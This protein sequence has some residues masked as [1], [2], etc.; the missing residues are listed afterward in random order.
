MFS[1][2]EQIKINSSYNRKTKKF[3]K[4]QDRNDHGFIFRI[5]GSAKYVFEN[6]TIVVNEG[7]IIFLPK[8]STYSYASLGGDVGS[9]TSINF[10]ADIPNGK[11]TVYC[12]DDYPYKNFILSD[13][14]KTW[15]LATTT[16]KFKCISV[17]YSFISTVSKIENIK[18]NNK[19]KIHLIEP[20]LDYLKQNIYDV[21]FKID[22]LH[23]FCGISS[24]YFRKIFKKIYNMTPQEYVL[25]NRLS[26]AKHI[27]ESKDY[28]SIYEVAKAVGFS[29]PLYFSKAYKKF[30]GFSPKRTN[31]LE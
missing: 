1:N 20:A 7:E 25:S 24:T 5:K 19:N 31:V 8:H 27:I 6:E 23:T 16:E 14:S 13:F 26:H 28:F 2:V 17:L 11:P 3:N 30:Y 21:N 9:Y 12:I 15:S 18:R 4:I 22:N 10:D 29:D